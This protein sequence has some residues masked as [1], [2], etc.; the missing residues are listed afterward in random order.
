M[1]CMGNVC[2]VG[3]FISLHE[4]D[5]LCLLTVAFGVGY[6]LTSFLNGRLFWGLIRFPTS[7]LCKSSK[8]VSLVLVSVV[9]VV[10]AVTIPLIDKFSLSTRWTGGNVHESWPDQYSRQY[11][12]HIRPCH[13]LVQCVLFS[14]CVIRNWVDHSTRYSVSTDCPLNITFYLYYIHLSHGFIISL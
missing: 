10:P 3:R 14:W 1:W 5:R 7:Y 11:S 12:C 9:P 8:L 6:G 4:P 2:N 13:S